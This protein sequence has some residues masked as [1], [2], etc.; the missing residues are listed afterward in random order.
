MLCCRERSRVCGFSGRRRR[1]KHLRGICPH[2]ARSRKGQHWFPLAVKPVSRS[3]ALRCVCEC[4]RVLC[5]VCARGGMA[6]LLTPHA[7]ARVYHL[8]RIF[9][10]QGQIKAL[11]DRPD[12][13]QEQPLPALACVPTLLVYIHLDPEKCHHHHHPTRTIGLEIPQR[14]RRGGVHADGGHVRPKGAPPYCPRRA[15]RV[16]PTAKASQVR[17]RAERS[18]EWYSSAVSRRP[19]PRGRSVPTLR[20][21][22]VIGGNRS[23]YRSDSPPR[24]ETVPGAF[25][26]GTPLVP[27]FPAWPCVSGLTVRGSSRPFV[28]A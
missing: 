16:G 5:V 17:P 14:V 27:V 26:A 20:L 1:V 11:R 18:V 9:L 28:F 12:P 3:F 6:P 10:A 25:N 24:R 22:F 2:A 7:D 8:G 13:P 23:G 19:A 21:S 4:V 15:H